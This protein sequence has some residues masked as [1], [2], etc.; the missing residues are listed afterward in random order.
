MMIAKIKMP[1]ANT[2]KIIFIAFYIINLT[3]TYLIGLA[4]ERVPHH[5][6][7]GAALYFALYGT[8]FD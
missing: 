3:N 5:I 8:Y 4:Q 1:Y 6:I 2:S 7:K